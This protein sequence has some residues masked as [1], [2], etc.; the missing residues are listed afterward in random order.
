[1]KAPWPSQL[2]K[3]II[4]QSSRKTAEIDS[5]GLKGGCQHPLSPSGLSQ[6]SFYNQ[7]PR[8]RAHKLLQTAYHGK[9]CLVSLLTTKETDRCHSWWLEPAWR[10]EAGQG[11]RFWSFCH[12]GLWLWL[13]WINRA[14]LL[15]YE[16][17]AIVTLALALRL[18]AG[19][20]TC[21]PLLRAWVRKDRVAKHCHISVL[22]PQE[23]SSVLESW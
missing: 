9:P 7:S 6:I 20:K 10:G 8:V 1:M 18:Q 3:G 14:L 16:D 19:D 4:C 21:L 17:W 11:W 12:L 5:E 2:I 15:C 22:C 13:L 23:M